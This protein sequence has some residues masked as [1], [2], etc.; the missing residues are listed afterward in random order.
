[1]DRVFLDLTLILHNQ[2]PVPKAPTALIISDDAS[3]LYV[4]D[5]KSG[6]SDKEISTFA[7]CCGPISP[8]KAIGDLI[9]TIQTMI[10]KGDIPKLRGYAL[11]VTLNSALRDLYANRT[12]LA[13]ADLNAFKLL[14]NAYIKNK[15]ISTTQ[16][17]ALIKSIT[18]IISQL[19]GTKSDESVIYPSERERSY[20]DNILRSKLG[21]IYPNPFSQSVTINYEI[22]ENKEALTKVQIM[23]YDINGRLLSTLVDNMMQSGCYTTSW[24]G[25][26]DKGGAAPYGTYFVIFR[27]GDVEEVSK[28][29][30]IKQ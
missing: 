12:K 17:N 2:I 4:I 7:I 13:I 10:N 6:T 27:A 18:A 11:I 15:Q 16:G 5:T 8:S 24:K 19:N 29:M 14:V 28:I 20:Q 30:L 26:F 3:K 21:V 25:D 22:A 23:I 9:I 1:M